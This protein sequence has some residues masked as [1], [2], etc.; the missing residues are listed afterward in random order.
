MATITDALLQHLAQRGPRRTLRIFAR[1]LLAGI[2][3]DDDVCRGRTYLIIAARSGDRYAGWLAA[4]YYRVGLFGFPRRQDLSEYWR[5][6]IERRLVGDLAYASDAELTARQK[7]YREW[8]S[9]RV[10]PA[11]TV[12][13]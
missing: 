2:F 8:R 4:L 13:G 6:R 10:E 1:M 5:E 11:N 3:G 7:A 9:Y 12:L